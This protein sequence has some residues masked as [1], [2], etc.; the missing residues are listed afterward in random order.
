LIGHSAGGHLAL[1]VASVPIP[2]KAVVALAPV[3]DLR[4]AHQLDLSKGAVTEFMGGTP[5]SMAD[6]YDEACPSNRASLVSTLIVHGTEDED[7]PI[8]ISRTFVDARKNNPEPPKLVEIPGAG[9]MD[10]ID[11]KSPAGIMVVDLIVQLARE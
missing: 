10:L 8:Q 2:V 9:H 1:R 7:V 11:P 5:A 3:A 4:L 6:C